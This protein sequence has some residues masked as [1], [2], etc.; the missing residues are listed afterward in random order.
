MEARRAERLARELDAFDHWFAAPNPSDGGHFL[1]A[2]LFAESPNTG[3]VARD[4]TAVFLNDAG[5]VEIVEDAR[6][7]VSELVGNVVNHVVPERGL[8]RPGGARRID[9]TF[10]VWPKWVF[11][12]VADEDSSPPLLPLGD[13]FSPG[14]AGELSEAVL[15]DNGRGLFIVQRLASSVWWRP[16]D[17]GGKTIWC[18]F[19]RDGGATERKAC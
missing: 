1:T 5:A 10:K 8:A 14:L 17:Q 6:L 4:M 11:I 9:M 7:V 19:D 2:T 3:R 18:R 15:P 13:A 12:G 16:G